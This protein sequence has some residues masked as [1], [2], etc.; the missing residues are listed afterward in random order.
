MTL[1][2]T[3]KSIIGIVKKLEK[4]ERTE[5]FCKLFLQIVLLDGKTDAALESAGPVD[6]V[7][8]IS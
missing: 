2:V 4:R 3:E 8:H 1:S 7:D 6:P 5:Q